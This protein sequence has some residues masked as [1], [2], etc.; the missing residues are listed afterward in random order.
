MTAR[1]DYV[2]IATAPA[3]ATAVGGSGTDASTRS[4][5]APRTHLRL[6]RRGRAVFGALATMLVIATLA[7]LALFTGTRAAASAESPA[8]GSAFGYVVVQPGASLWEV[9]ESIDS[10]TDPRDLVAE[11]IRLNQFDD[12]GVQAGQPIAVPLRYADAPGVLTA[13]ELGL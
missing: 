13:G 5:H 12:S 9:A 4:A 11:I 1:I 3:Y 7:V 2:Q 10:G 8:E 6:T